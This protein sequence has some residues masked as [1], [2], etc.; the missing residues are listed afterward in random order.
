MCRAGRKQQKR[1]AGE[2]RVELIADNRE[3]KPRSVRLAER[4]RKSERE[5]VSVGLSWSLGAVNLPR[6][7]HRVYSLARESP[8]IYYAQQQQCK[9]IRDIMHTQH[10]RVISR[11]ERECD[12]A[13]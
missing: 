4:P 6:K 10:V 3:K 2:L 12:V 1:Y 13:R 9:V 11:A 7:T 5:E 8:R